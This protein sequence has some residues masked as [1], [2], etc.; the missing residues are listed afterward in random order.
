MRKT[1]LFGCVISICSLS[2]YSNAQATDSS[3]LVDSLKGGE[4]TKTKIW[5]K[6][7]PFE[8]NTKAVKIVPYGFVRNDFYYDSRENFETA[9]GLF[10]VIPKDRD[11]NA[12]GEDLND[13]SSSRFLSIATRIGVK[14]YSNI[15]ILKSQLMAQVE[16]DFAGYSGST[17]MLRIRQAFVKMDWEKW[18]FLAGQTWHPMFG[19]VVPEVQSLATGSPFQ[20][21]N[22]SP[23]IRIDAKTFG[24]RGTE[25]RVFASA[26]YQFQYASVGP[27]GSSP[28][29]QTN[30]K[31][32]EAYLGLELKNA[33][34]LF[35]VGAEMTT[36]KPRDYELSA[37][38]TCTY[39]T[40]RTFMSM[41][42]NA[43][44]Q[45]ITPN[46]KFRVRAKSIYGGNMSHLLLL[47]G[48]AEIDDKLSGARYYYD[49]KTWTS[50]LNL[51]Y[52]TKWQVGV[53]GGYMKNFGIDHRLLLPD[54]S[55]EVYMFGYN[56]IAGA[57]RISPMLC[58]N[59]KHFSFG[60]EY[61]MTATSYGKWE[62]SKD[63]FYSTVENTHWVKNHR[64]VAV[65]ML[66]F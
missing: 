48:Y 12:L 14:V 23:Q 28:K 60:V 41:A 37:D 7:H 11:L 52:G 38:N 21:F 22:R 56:N 44:L 1:F 20:P 15:P 6:E 3:V 40:D 49:V 63:L 66:H 50:W 10:Y 34:F 47:S 17:T 53:F 29:Y 26:I 27:D 36:L 13:V 62:D 39:I 4:N 57:Y 24:N 65:M 42:W 31:V 8:V 16:T 54:V 32:P 19:T 43:Y 2:G 33:G 5:D 51:V 64:V 9:S 30:A 45:Y 18:S 46:G 25:F 35:G 55:S 58:Y 61:E 59:L